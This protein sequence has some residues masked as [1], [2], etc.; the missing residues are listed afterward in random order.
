MQLYEVILKRHIQ[1][2]ND[3]YMY[4]YI[5]AYIIYKFTKY[6]YNGVIPIINIF[7]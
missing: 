7:V 2:V 4:I 6:V 5:Y 3:I 1:I